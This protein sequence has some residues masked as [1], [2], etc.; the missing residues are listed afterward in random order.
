LTASLSSSVGYEKGKT[1]ETENPKE[2]DGSSWGRI[3]ISKLLSR[4]GQVM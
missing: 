2:G 1:T 4:P 3:T